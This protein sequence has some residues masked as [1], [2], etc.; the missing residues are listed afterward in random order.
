MKR[1]SS[2]IYRPTTESEELYLYAINTSECYHQIIQPVLVNLKKKVA[3]GVY[4]A[5]KA[6]DLYYYAATRCAKQYEREYGSE[7][8]YGITFSVTDR[9]TCAVDLE[10]RF[11]EDLGL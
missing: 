6:V 1:T 11:R 10:E 3:K 2:M 9:F 8:W 4:D 5:D 7:A